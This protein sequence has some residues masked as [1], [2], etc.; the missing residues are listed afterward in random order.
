MVN[1][2]HIVFTGSMWMS[3][4]SK[5]KLKGLYAITSPNLSGD[6]LMAQTQKA[7]ISGIGILQYR[8]KTADLAQQEY[9]ANILSTLCKKNNVIFIINDNIELALAV[10]A[11]GVHLGQSDQNI[12][13][14]RQQ[15]GGNKIIG[16]TC[17]NKIDYALTAQQQGADYVAFGRFFNSTTKPTAPLAD[18]SLLQQAKKVITLPI[19]AIG[20]ITHQLAPLVLNEGVDMIAVIQGIF[21]EKDIPTAVQKFVQIINTPQS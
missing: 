7:I 16:V 10:N 13:Y 5:N 14:A 21:S 1:S 2:F 18:L 4:V 8:N 15:L 9:E 6:D 19:V 3:S 11:D 17:N 12:E 20:G